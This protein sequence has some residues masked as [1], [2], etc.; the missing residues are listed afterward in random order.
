[1][2]DPMKCKCGEMPTMLKGQQWWHCGTC[3]ISGPYNDSDHVGWDALMG[4]SGEPKEGTVRVRIPVYERHGRLY[5]FYERLSNGRERAGV[6]FTTD[7][8]CAYI[9]AD[10]PLASP[11]EVKGEVS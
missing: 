1:M 2:T 7:K 9:T 6:G 3:G 10:I 8:V 11:T 4:G 5:V